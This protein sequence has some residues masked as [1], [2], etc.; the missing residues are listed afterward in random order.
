MG[1]LAVTTF[2]IGQQLGEHQGGMKMDWIYFFEKKEQ[3]LNQG[4]ERN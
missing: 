3:F 4:G 2:R 1:R